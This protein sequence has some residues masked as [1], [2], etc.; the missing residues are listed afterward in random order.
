MYLDGEKVTLDTMTAAVQEKM[1][2]TVSRSKL[3]KQL[4]QIGF[5]FRNVNNRKLL[6]EKPQVTAARNAFIRRVLKM[7]QQTPDRDIIYLDETSPLQ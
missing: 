4:L 7:R 3:R 5:K 6:T 2:K 1:E